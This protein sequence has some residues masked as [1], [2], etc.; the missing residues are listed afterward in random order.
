MAFIKA[1]IEEHRGSRAYQTALDA[2]QYYDGVNPTI[3]RKAINAI[4]QALAA[5][6]AMAA[7]AAAGAGG[8]SS[9]T[10]HAG[11]L[12][13]VPYNGY[14]A[15]LHKGESVLT[16][17]EAEYLRS[18]RLNGISSA[19]I[20]IVQNIESVPQTP[21]ELAEATAAYFEQARWAIA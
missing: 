20:T 1:A 17:T 9:A 6:Q 12:D 5:A 7:A 18:G 15:I 4:K 10:G 14:P 21:V 3:N 8:D 11:G 2:Q 19:G 16:A 13:Y